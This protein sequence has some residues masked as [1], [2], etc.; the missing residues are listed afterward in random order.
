MQ[1]TERDLPNGT[2]KTWWATVHRVWQN[3]DVARC[4]NPKMGPSIKKEKISYLCPY[5]TPVKCHN[6]VKKN[7]NLL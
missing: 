4:E 2:G 6:F 7:Q 3:D 1:E 5:H